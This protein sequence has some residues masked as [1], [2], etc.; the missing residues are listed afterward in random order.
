M[1]FRIEDM[2]CGG[3]AR[4]V[5]AAIR[6]LDPAA[7]VEADPPARRVTVRTAAPQAAIMAALAEAGFPAV[8]E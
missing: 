3:C 7:V 6:A 2:T 5:T 4:S 1:Q 8:A